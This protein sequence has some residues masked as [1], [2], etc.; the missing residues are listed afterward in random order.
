MEND[1]TSIINNLGSIEIIILLFVLAEVITPI[2][3]LGIYHLKGKRS[4]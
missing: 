1:Y 4:K 3:V 2:I